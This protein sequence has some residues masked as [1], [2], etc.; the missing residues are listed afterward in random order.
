MAWLCSQWGAL[1]SQ[2]YEQDYGLMIRMTMLRNAYSAVSKMRSLSGDAINK[3]LTH[4]ERI[5]LGKLREMGLL[6]GLG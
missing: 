5:L 4:N 3:A 1:P 6:K 2:V